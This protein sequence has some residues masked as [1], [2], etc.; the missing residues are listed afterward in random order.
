MNISDDLELYTS[1]MEI[2]WELHYIAASLF[3]VEL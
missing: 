2:M 1:N 3:N